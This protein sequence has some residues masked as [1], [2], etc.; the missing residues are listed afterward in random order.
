MN[1]ETNR[2][3]FDAIVEID[4]TYVGGKPRKL[5]NAQTS[6]ESKRGRGSRK[7]PVVGIFERA[8][9]EVYARVAVPDREGKK[10]TGKQ[11]FSIVDKDHTITFHQNIFRLT[12]TNFPG[13]F[14]TERT[15]I[16]STIL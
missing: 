10:L 16:F 7:T 1:Q 12:S 6:N 14:Q 15:R 4:E 5:W 8:T 2:R 9:G 11:L 13:D 3:L